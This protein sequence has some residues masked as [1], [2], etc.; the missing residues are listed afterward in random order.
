MADY[1]RKLSQ[2]EHRNIVR[3][4]KQHRDANGGIFVSRTRRRLLGIKDEKSGLFR[5]DTPDF[6]LDVRSNVKTALTDLQLI[7]EVANQDQLKEM[8]SV[9]PYSLRKSDPTKASLANVIEALFYTLIQYKRDKDGLTPIFD[10]KNI[11]WK[12]ELSNEIVQKCLEFY[13]TNG[14]ITSKAHERLVMEVTDMLG[15]ELSHT[16]SRELKLPYFAKFH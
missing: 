1:R 5:E 15:S 8:F 12:A 2:T 6:W 14:M 11:V 7:C 4:Y 10:Q 9:I 16:L 13:N 3:K